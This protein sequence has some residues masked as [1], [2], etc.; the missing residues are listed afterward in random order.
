METYVV[1]S[2]GKSLA[3]PM[4]VEELEHATVRAAGVF[5]MD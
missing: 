1:S 4:T 3:D 2:D 5:L